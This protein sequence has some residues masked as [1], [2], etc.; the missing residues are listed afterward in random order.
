M[1][2]HCASCGRADA[3]LKACTACKLVKYC[4]VECQ[5]AHRSAHKK[6]CKK[7]AR[8]LFDVQLFALPPKTEE[9]PICMIP[10]PYSDDESSYMSCCGKT[11]CNGCRYCLTRDC[12]PFCN[13]AHPTSPEETMMRFAER[14][15]KYN[16]PEAMVLLAMYHSTGEYGLP[17][18]KS[19]AFELLQ[20]AS[21]LGS[22][23]GHDHL[24]TTYRMGDGI[25]IDMKKSVH[26]YQ[27]A[28]MMG[29]VTSR[30]HC[31]ITR[32]YEE[33][34]SEQRDRAAVIIAGEQE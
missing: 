5:V 1:S 22:A 27:I 14:I 19:K 13:T 16:D 7:R 34:K 10:L 29:H 20:R 4:G 32:Q 26:H 30:K 9:C 3:S 15:E 25:E 31:E 28:T 11:I 8:E 17:V 23:T 24:G 2:Y 21:E 18:D 6:A 33:T 12:C